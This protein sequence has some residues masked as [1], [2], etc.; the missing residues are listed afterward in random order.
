MPATTAAV[1]EASPTE[2][3]GRA[4]G[5][6]HAAHQLGDVIGVAFLGTLV[7]QR[8]YLVAGLHLDMA[9]SGV[10]FLLGAAPSLWSM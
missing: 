5:S 4:S 7:A 3:V 9:I 6:L 8:Q 2:R 10:A 1:I